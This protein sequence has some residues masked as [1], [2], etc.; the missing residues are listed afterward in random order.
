MARKNRKKRPAQDS[1]KSIGKLLFLAA[2]ILIA[3]FALKD[4]W[5]NIWSELKRTSWKVIAGVFFLGV[6]YNCCDGCALTKLLRTC[7]QKFPWHEGILCSFYYS[8]FRVITF[9]S[10]TAPAGMYYVSR[11]GIPV[12]RSL[13]IFTI[14]Y[15]IQRIA[16]C[17][18]F[19]F[20]FIS[21][22]GAMDQYFG[23]YKPYMAAGVALAAVAAAALITACIC[24]PLHRCLFTFAEKAIRKEKTKEKLAGWKEKASIVRKEAKAL[25]KNKKLLLELLILNFFKLSAWYLI[26]VTIFHMLNSPELSFYMAAAAMMTALSGVIPAPG[27]VG[28]VEFIFV[29]LFTPLTGKTAAASGML[30]YRFTTYILPFLLGAAIALKIHSPSSHQPKQ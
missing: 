19:L 10:G 29:L 7:D 23:K 30:L 14:N 13:G 20:S 18:Y 8:F 26:P 5:G 4:S 6:L 24:A 27:G 17:L 25:L 11:K 28:A 3:V 12:S 2:V 9:G 22:Y 21:N 1:W 15:T 16:V